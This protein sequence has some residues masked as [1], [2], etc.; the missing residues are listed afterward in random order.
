MRLGNGNWSGYKGS[1]LITTLAIVTVLCV[2]MAS[3]W[4][5]GESRTFTTRK[6]GDRGRALSIAEA[7]IAKACAVLATNW[8]L[9]TQPAAFPATAYGG[10]TYDVAVTSVGSNRASLCSTGTFGSVTESAVLD[11]VNN[12][13]PTG[14]GGGGGA[15]TGAY[16]CAIMANGPITLSGSVE[17]NVGTNG[18]VHGNST[19]SKSGTGNFRAK[20]LEFVG[21]TSM[22]GG[23]TFYSDFNAGGNCTVSGS[24]RIMNNIWCDAFQSSGS[25]KVMGNGTVLTY[26]KTGTSGIMGTLVTNVNNTVPALAIPDL[27]LDA[28]YNW[29]LANGE[30][31]SNKSISGSA[32]VEPVGGIM[33]V[34]GTLN[35]SGSG[36]LVG[37]FIAT[38]NISI[39]GSGNQIKVSNYPALVSRDGNITI[40]GSQSFHGLLYAKT[41]SFS[42]SGSGAVVGSIICGGS[43]TASGSWGVLTYE[44]STPIP[45]GGGGGGG[46][47]VSNNLDITA[48]QR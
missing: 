18:I 27:G 41:G 4:V 17:F 35:I 38:G 40:S 23:W 7:G 31:Y 8:D 43:F 48:W 6:L 37:C 47:S 24:G 5:V 42:K 13:V 30:V 28:Y 29:A 14:G 9:R 11:V 12:A 33:W 19:F 45:P 21:A 22:S 36:N 15:P 32:T 20:T 26:K 16:A 1:A 10:G 34:N 44:D 25:F 46:G 2:L 39:S 3:V